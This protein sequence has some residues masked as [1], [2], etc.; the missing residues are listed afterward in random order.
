MKIIIF[1]CSLA[2]CLAFMYGVGCFYF[3]TT[4]IAQWSEGGRFAFVSF[5][6]VALFVSSYIFAI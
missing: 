1:V 2:F 3:V 5:T 4:D 6:P